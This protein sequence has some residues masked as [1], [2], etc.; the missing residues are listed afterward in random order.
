[1]NDPSST[2][3]GARGAIR[4][5]SRAL[6]R[7]GLR[8]RLTIAFALAAA[9][10][11]AFVAA[12]RTLPGGVHDG[13][14]PLVL[15]AWLA[16]AAAA[17]IAALA[18]G[19]R[20]PVATTHAAA[21]LERNAAA[22]H[23]ALVNL[24]CVDAEPA[25]AYAR[26][27]A[28][29]Q[30]VRALEGVD[31]RRALSVRGG[32]S[33]RAALALLIAAWTAAAVLSDKP[34]LPSLLRFFA[35]PVAAPSA[36][37][38]RRSAPPGDA[39]IYAGTAVD[40]EFELGGRIPASV[41]LQLFDAAGAVAAEMTAAP[42]LER[43]AVR[44]ALSPL[45]VQDAIC[46]R[47]RAGDAVL[48]EVIA[49]A[50][51]PRIESIEL[52][53]TPPDYTG[54]APH[55][56]AAGDVR[57]LTGTRAAFEVSANTPLAGGILAIG[58]GPRQSRTR[59]TIDASDPRRARAE[60]RLTSDGAYAITAHDLFGTEAAAPPVFQIAVVADQ[61]PRVVV[62]HTDE[63]PIDGPID[64]AGTAALLC[65][66]A[67]DVGV[68]AL[69]LVFVLDG[70]EQSI[71]LR[72]DQAGPELETPISLVGFPLDVGASARAWVEATDGR[73][74]SDGRAAPQTARSNEFLLVRS[75]SRTPSAT[76]RASTRD[77]HERSDETPATAAQP[78]ER[79]ADADPTAGEPAT[80]PSADLQPSP[81][82]QPSADDDSAAAIDEF[83]EQH[84]HEAAEAAEIPRSPTADS[85]PAALD[86]P[87]REPPSSQPSS[88]PTA[89]PPSTQPGESGPGRSSDAASEQGDAARP[90][91]QRPAAQ[92]D[93]GL[94]EPAGERD[95]DAAQRNRS[96]REGGESD[97]PQEKSGRS[98]EPSTGT[99]GDPP[100]GSRPADAG[101]DA[102]RDGQAPEG[103]PDREAPGDGSPQTSGGDRPA[104]DG[105]RAEGADR[106][107]AGRA[108]VRELI[109]RARRGD[110]PTVE[111][112]V[113]AGWPKQKASEFTEA[114]R[115]LAAE[116]GRADPNG[117]ARIRSAV[118]E[119]DLAVQRGG[120]AR[121][122]AGAAR[123][124]D[125]EEARAALKR[126]A[127]PP[128][129][130]SPEGLE[131]LLAAY[132][133]AIARAAAERPSVPGRA[134]SGG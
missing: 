49:V 131:D 6:R 112:L 126:V 12:D 44:F 80:R 100:N 86:A 48:E 82:S 22:P 123:G 69:R 7:A 95:G 108:A 29:R 4:A 65:Q 20:R 132:Y 56:V 36:T 102:G 75:V 41:A 2:V 25:F 62:S 104:D 103:A 54:W 88:K 3:L 91:G 46:Y 76:Q 37:T 14:R 105:A 13:V 26:A 58:V 30:A 45:L 90:G 73:V 31:L 59:L 133:R 117:P 32:G 55:R 23:N 113:R 114:L 39:P 115:R 5:A 11:I 43:A 118:Q 107:A 18:G 67:D 79:E 8:R 83:I 111:D 77:G 122:G 57:V 119:G 47:C 53:L 63:S 130:Q 50:P 52:L 27:A 34:L 116:S 85:Q 98:G 40:L 16:G 93:E 38:L 84:G 96:N 15:A 17:F 97:Q 68:D 21:W 33:A 19:L 106:D 129:E 124:A 81:D 101:A 121:P 9:A 134:P 99:P 110:A 78:A 127:P 89:D 24:A 66:S 71:S 10:P 125:A 70:F 60:L 74:N 128:D 28:E 64:V 72:T 42:T 109:D 1:M 87:Q 61:P 92:S 94:D 120:A 35:A 51:R